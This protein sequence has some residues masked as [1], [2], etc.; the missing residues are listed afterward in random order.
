[1]KAGLASAV[2][3]L[4][5]CGEVMGAKLPLVR[6]IPPDPYPTTYTGPADTHTEK[7]H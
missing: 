7:R 3:A 4:A 6:H 5:A 1:M 2:A